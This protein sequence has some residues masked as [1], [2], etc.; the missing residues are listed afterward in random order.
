M[1][2]L[3]VNHTG[4]VSGAERSLLGLLG[5]LEPDV[6]PC[7]VCP[8]G[9]LYDRAFASGIPTA[10]IPEVMGSLKLH[11][12]HTPLAIGAMASG[13]LSLLREARRWRVDLVHANSIRTGMVAMPAS[14]AL[15]RPLVTTVR[16]C[17]PP[18]SLSRFI[19]ASLL[20]H[21]AGLVAISQHVARVVDPEG[22]AAR[23]IVSDDPFDL[24]EFDPARCDRAAAREQL[25]IAQDALVLVLVGQ[26]TPWKGHEEAIHALASVRRSHPSATL[27]IV[28]EAKFVAHATRYDNVTYLRRLH[29]IAHDLELGDAVR[30]LGEK[31]PVSE[32]LRASDVSLVPS[33]EEPFGRV[34]VEAMAMGLPVI[35]TSVGGPAEVIDDGVDGVLVSPR[36]PEALAAAITRLL[37]HEDER[38]RMGAAARRTAVRRFGDRARHASEMTAFYREILTQHRSYAAAT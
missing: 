25:G 9:P 17:L 20:G 32:I 13:S 38:N 10:A 7:L 34:V 19:Q 1:R 15:R 2:V 33:W 29:E 35:A 26:I 21:G 11:P 6:E 4:L 30:F 18:S 37:D 16:D 31:E 14:R 28:G 22:G 24:S 5:T 23:L 36:R 12:L 8:P 3:Y 27:M